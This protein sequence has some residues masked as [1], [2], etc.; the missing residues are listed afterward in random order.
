MLTKPSP[1]GHFQLE[2]PELDLNKRILTGRNSPVNQY[3]KYPLNGMPII[4]S[5]INAN[6]KCGHICPIKLK[7]KS[8]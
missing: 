5:P 1:R 3:S 7:G 4:Q 8:L 6:A 2:F